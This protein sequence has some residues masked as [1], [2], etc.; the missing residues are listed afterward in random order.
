ML[1][2]FLMI[3]ILFALVAWAWTGIFL[4]L[5]AI[6]RPHSDFLQQRN[7]LR[8]AIDLFNIEVLF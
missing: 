5:A 7:G 1:T 3:P 2:F 6:G 8:L 4:Y